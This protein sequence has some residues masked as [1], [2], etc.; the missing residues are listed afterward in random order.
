MALHWNVDHARRLV[1]LKSEAVV[2]Y[3]EIEDYMAALRGAGALS[4]RKL[5]DARDGHTEMTRQE[6]MSY[7]GAI[8]GYSSIDRLGP[9]AVVVGRGSHRAHA[10]I[11]TQ[12][13]VTETR[14]IRLFWEHDA[15]LDWLCAQPLPSTPE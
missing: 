6:L 15:A 7:A 12:M 1:T 9:Y 11:L 13:L 4:Y 2:R 5:F 10:P 14:P 8:A 3:S